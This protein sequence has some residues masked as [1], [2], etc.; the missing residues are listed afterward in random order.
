MRAEGGFVFV[1]QQKRQSREDKF[2]DEKFVS[3]SKM[4]RSP[5]GQPAEADRRPIWL[6]G[7]KRSEK[8]GKLMRRAYLELFD[9]P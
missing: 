6:S 2:D 1:F 4:R 7:E 9:V 3:A 8:G 5:L